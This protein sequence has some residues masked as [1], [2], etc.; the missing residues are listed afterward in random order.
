[1]KNTILKMKTITLILVMV[2]FCNYGKAQVVP[3]TFTNTST[4][5]DDQIYVAIVG[6][7]AGHVWI[8]CKTGA[9]NPMN[10][11]DN[12]ISGPIINGN[13]GPGGNGKY[14]NCF[15]KLSEIPNK[16]VNIPLI[17]GCRILISFK[18]Q[19]YLYFYGYSGS[20]NLLL[21]KICFTYRLYRN[22]I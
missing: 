1:M 10:V 20:P 5:A 15:T 18:S 6:I 4:Y 3:Y 22:R 14:A 19:L 12:T 16:T 21:Q 7:T 9:V 2:L 11:A 17:A 13:T 8:D